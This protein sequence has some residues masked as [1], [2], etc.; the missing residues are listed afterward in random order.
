MTEEN[1]W[2]ESKLKIIS[3]RKVWHRITKTQEIFVNVSWVL[4]SSFWTELSLLSLFPLSD[5]TQ[6]EPTR[7]KKYQKSWFSNTLALWNL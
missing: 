1:A 4:P 3:K 5:P 6:P 2:E 7:P